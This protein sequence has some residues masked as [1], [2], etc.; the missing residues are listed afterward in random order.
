MHEDESPNPFVAFAT[1]ARRRFGSAPPF[2]QLD[3]WVVSPGGVGT[4]ALMSHV[5]A[6]LRVNEL[7]DNDGLKHWPRPP[8][9]RIEMSGTKVLFVTGDPA[10]ICRSIKRRRWTA[11]QAMKLGSL[12]AP[13]LSGWRQL[14]ALHDAVEAQRKSWLALTSD[15]F[16]AID[17]EAIWDSADMLA[18]FFGVEDPAFVKDFPRRRSRLSRRP[19]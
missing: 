7:D 19:Y 13:L 2:E 11:T 8:L 5:A 14:R 6:F 3:A 10:V 17:Y 16:R 4:T 1:A 15:R 12:S 9:R 18:D